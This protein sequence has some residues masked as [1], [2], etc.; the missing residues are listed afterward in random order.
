MTRDISHM[1]KASRNP[2]EVH[3]KTEGIKKKKKIA[4]ILSEFT[5]LFF[6]ESIS[7]K[8]KS[9]IVINPILKNRKAN[10]SG[11]P[12]RVKIL[13][14]KYNSQRNILGTAI[15]PLPY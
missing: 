13:G 15:H 1:I 5:L 11:T 8:V 3:K 2:I 10:M 7:K 4:G 14:G 6:R 12:T 9:V